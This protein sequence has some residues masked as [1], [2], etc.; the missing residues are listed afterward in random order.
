MDR[1]QREHEERLV[2]VSVEMRPS[3]EASAPV[4][5]AEGTRDARGGSCSCCFRCSVVVA[6]VMGLMVVALVLAFIAH[7]VLLRP[8]CSQSYARDATALTPDAKLILTC[9]VKNGDKEGRHDIFTTEKAGI[10]FIFG[11]VKVPD[12]TNQEI[13]LK[14]MRNGT[15]ISIQK[16][17][18]EDHKVFFFD[19]VTIQRQRGGLDET[20]LRSERKRA[21]G[22]RALRERKNLGKSESKPFINLS[23]IYLIG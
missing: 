10:F 22:Q 15:S 7:H 21:E 6:I 1:N 23:G 19:K 17:R 4:R 5:A 12:V 3:L 11:W 16:K 9:K 8:P 20:E 18:I 14:Q 13:I 2:E